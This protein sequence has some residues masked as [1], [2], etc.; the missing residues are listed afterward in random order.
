MSLSRRDFMSALAIA[1]SAAPALTYARALAPFN[2]DADRSLFRHGV[3]SGDPLAQRVVLWTR[4]TPREASKEPIEVEWVVARD[5]E[6]RHIVAHDDVSTHA[7]RDY[8]V[9]VD[10]EDLEPGT[11]YYYRFRVGGVHSPLGRTRTL[12]VGRVDRLRLAVTSCSNYPYGFFNVYGLIGQQ[13]DLDAVLHLGDYLY[14]YANGEYGDGTALNRLPEPL[15]EIV[16]LQDYRSR[17]ALYKTDPDLQEAHRQ[18]PFI[19]I[20]DDHETANNS[21]MGGAENHQPATEGD[22]QARKAAALRAYFEWMPIRENRFQIEQLKAGLTP[23]IYRNFRFGNLAELTMLDTRLIGRDLQAASPKDVATINNPTRQLLGA[24]QE[25]WL[26]SSLSRSL[27]QRV[28]WRVLGQQIMMAQLSLDGGRSIANEDQWDGYKP[29]R[30][31]LFNHIH[32]RKI[33]NMVVLSGDIHSSWANDLAPNPFDA[34]YNATS[35]A[36]SLG[37]EF[38]TPG[39]TSPFLFPDTPAGAAQAQGTANFIRSIS[40]HI[41]SA[42][43]L[44]RGYLL[45]DIDRERVQSEWYYPKTVAQRLLQQ[46]AG[47]IL[48]SASGSNHLV[49]GSTPSVPKPDAAPLAT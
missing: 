10:V 12:P 9:K 41:R 33:S 23:P 39:V 13:A 46:D 27:E 40:P 16:A 19:T 31:R 4:I 32:T 38:V 30:D 36:G 45:L 44:R 20:W 43:L 15:T 28:Q 1:G 24:A 21:W 37:V 25:N 3:A 5:P 35:G 26:F 47:A 49:A 8:T 18:H 6:M 17:H 42:E 7:G 2:G 48:Y 14:E 11:T 29:A 22:W 34:S